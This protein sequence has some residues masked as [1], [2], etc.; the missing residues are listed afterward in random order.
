MGYESVRWH[1]PRCTGNAALTYPK[2]APKVL[3][4][5]EGFTERRFVNEFMR[6]QMPSINWIGSVVP[7]SSQ[8]S[9]LQRRGGYTTYAHIRKFILNLLNDSSA[10]AVTTMF[11]FDL[12]GLPADLPGINKVPAGTPHQRVAHLEKAFLDDIA[13]RRFVPYFSLHDFEAL[14]FSDPAKFRAWDPRLTD[15]IIA[16]L[17]AIRDQ[18]DSPEHINDNQPP[19]HRIAGLMPHFAIDKPTVGFVVAEA[20]GLPT[21]RQHCPHFDNWLNTLS[22]LLP[23]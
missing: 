3:V 13:D 7:H 16:D 4:A 19:T 23:T 11:D 8:T 12:D 6:A 18:Y 22:A 20:I 14:L 2:I 15:S 1:D 5:V 10:M 17:T 21:L 9:G